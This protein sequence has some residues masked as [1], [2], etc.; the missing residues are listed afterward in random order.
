M[1]DNRNFELEFKE[2]I[3]TEI[4]TSP[5]NSSTQ[6]I[7]SFDLVMCL[8]VVLFKILAILAYFIPMMIGHLE[9]LT[10]V[11]VVVL[12]SVDFWTTKNLCGR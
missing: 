5:K 4:A 3:A 1:D 2:D 6:I 8:F 11:L 7:M 12:T 10:F 9:L